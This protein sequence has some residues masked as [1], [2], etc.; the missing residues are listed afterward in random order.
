MNYLTLP[1]YA[2]TKGTINVVVEVS[3]GTYDKYEIDEH[4]GDKLTCVRTLHKGFP[5]DCKYAYNYGFIPSTYA[6]DHD[7]LDAIILCSEKIEPLTVVKCKVVGVVP[8][9]DTGEI[10]DK[11]IC[12]PENSELIKNTKLFKKYLNEAIKYL[13]YYKYP[14]QKATLVKEFLGPI[15]A[16]SIIDKHLIGQKQPLVTNLP[17]GDPFGVSIDR[18]NF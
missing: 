1:A 4:T 10:D 17:K 7:Q 6:E 12:V 8:T 18:I 15:E 2:D 13:K 9:I 14:D 5:K 16:Y 3:K 11:I